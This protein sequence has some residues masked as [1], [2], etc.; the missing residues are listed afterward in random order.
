MAIKLYQWDTSVVDRLVSPAKFDGAY[1][2]QWHQHGY[3]SM[4]VE[5]AA[6]FNTLNDNVLVK[7]NADGVTAVKAWLKPNTDKEK[8]TNIRKKYDANA[9]FFA[10]RTNDTAIKNDIA[11]I[12]AAVETERDTWLDVS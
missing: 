2:I 7:S 5:F 8:V 4:T 6:L 9:E 10:L 12:V 11:S 3:V 1:K